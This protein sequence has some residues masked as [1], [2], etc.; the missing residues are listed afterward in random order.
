MNVKVAL[1]LRRMKLKSFSVEHGHKL[2]QDRLQGNIVVD[3][4]LKG[5]FSPK[6]NIVISVERICFIRINFQFG[7]FE[8]MRQMHSENQTLHHAAIILLHTIK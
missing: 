5:Q 7:C 4:P 8:E 6:S 3:C 2:T 1:S